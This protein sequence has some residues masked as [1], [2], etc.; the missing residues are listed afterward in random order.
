M[1]FCRGVPRPGF[2]LI[3]TLSFGAPLTAIAQS[4]LPLA[5]AER[6]ALERAPLYAHHN[7]KV[8]AAAERVVY[9]GRL[10]DPQLTLGAI[11]VPV[12]SFSLR[13]EDMTMSM[14]GVRQAFPPGDTLNIR[15]RRAEQ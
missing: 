10:A 13:K 9:E 15:T 2:L 5:E 8:S 12:D 11:N 7:S 1:F 14:V 3:S 6:L 4:Q